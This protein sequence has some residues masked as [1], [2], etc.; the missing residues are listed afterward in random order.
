MCLIFSLE[1]GGIHC[2]FNIL[3]ILVKAGLIDSVSAEQAME[4]KLKMQMI[5]DLV[6]QKVAKP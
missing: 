4:E 6:D 5:I 3:T 1:A 2:L